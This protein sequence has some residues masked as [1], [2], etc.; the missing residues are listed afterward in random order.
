MLY[1]DLVDSIEDI[2]MMSKGRNHVMA[3]CFLR[4]IIDEG[5]GACSSNCVLYDGVDG[6]YCIRGWVWMVE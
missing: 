6:R 5:S 1:S 3:W 2:K 4:D